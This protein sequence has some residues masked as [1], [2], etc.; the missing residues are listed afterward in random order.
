MALDNEV[1]ETHSRGQ[2]WRISWHPPALPPPDGG[3]HGS[4]ALCFAQDGQVV[5]V[6]EDGGFSWVMPGGRPEAGED[7]RQTLGREV[8]EEACAVVEDARLLGYMRG[9]CVKG[10]E[11]G[12]VIVRAHWWA[13]VRLL[14][15][16]PRHEMT[17]RVVVPPETAFELIAPTWDNDPTLRRLFHEAM[18]SSATAI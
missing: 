12:L 18:T 5:V 16:E 14:K 7:L 3:N 8:F 4:A 2:D 13:R 11:Q 1:F 15:W 6:S 10:R 9:V 17:H